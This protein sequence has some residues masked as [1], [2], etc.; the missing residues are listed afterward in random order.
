M[1]FA[2]CICVTLARRTANCETHVGQ[3]LHARRSA[4]FQPRAHSSSGLSAV[5]LRLLKVLKFDCSSWV[6]DTH[7]AGQL[8]VMKCRWRGSLHVLSSCR[9]DYEE[10][11]HQI[12]SSVVSRACR[13]KK[14]SADIRAGC[15]HPQK[16]QRYRR[17][18]HGPAPWFGAAGFRRVGRSIPSALLLLEYA[19]PS[20]HHGRSQRQFGFHGRSQHQSTYHGRSRYQSGY[21]GRSRHK[22][23]KRT[24]K[25]T[26]SATGA[27]EHVEEG[28]RV[29]AER[30]TRLKKLV[31]VRSGGKS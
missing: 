16:S 21:H 4:S 1:P 2:G 29:A 27:K 18:A 6:H 14:E 9:V 13:E 20:P 7:R 28:T 25:N 10:E 11:Y 17:G 23:K 12:G 22:S 19:W 15:V 24:K 8:V 26:G 30:R 3:M 31:S 5:A